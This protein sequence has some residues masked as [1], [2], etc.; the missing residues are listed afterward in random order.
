MDGRRDLNAVYDKM[1]RDI[2]GKRPLGNAAQRYVEDMVR[3]RQHSA[4]GRSLHLGTHVPTGQPEYFPLNDRSY[5]E[6]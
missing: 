2:R 5:V 4:R 6:V 1:A 3:S